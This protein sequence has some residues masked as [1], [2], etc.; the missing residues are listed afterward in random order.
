[1]NTVLAR[2]SVP[3]AP[4]LSAEPERLA[5]LRA[6]GIIDAPPPEGC[7][8][9]V[10]CVARY[11]RVPVAFFS[12]ID[13]TR[14][15]FMASCGLAVEGSAR[16]DSFCQRTIRQRGIY[17][18]RDAAI[19]PL[20]ASNPFVLTEPFFRFYAGVP[21]LIDQRH[22]IGSLCIVDHRPRTLDEAQKGMLRHFSLILAGLI[23]IRHLDEE[24]NRLLPQEAR[25]SGHA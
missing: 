1:M 3:P 11:F 10:E 16:E 6:L 25:Y 4:A 18:V 24:K 2:L 17:S 15:Y 8:T 14:Q 12:V 21:V 5:C 19:D 20:Y 13:E 23:E 9:L 22:A 7:A